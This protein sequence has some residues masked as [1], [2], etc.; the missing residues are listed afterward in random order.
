MAHAEPA[1]TA[2]KPSIDALRADVAKRRSGGAK[3]AGGRERRVTQAIRHV[4]A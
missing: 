2:A 4:L 3:C 1:H